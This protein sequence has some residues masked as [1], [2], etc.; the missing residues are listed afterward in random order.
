M[1]GKSGSY[2]SDFGHSLFLVYYW[3]QTKKNLL[4]QATFSVKYAHC[5]QNCHGYTN[6]FIII[7]FINCKWVDTQWQWSFYILHTHG[8]WRSITLDLVGEGYMGS[9]WWQLA[10][11]NNR[12][13]PS[14][15][16]RTQENQEKPV[17][18]WPVAGPSSYW[19]LSCCLASK[20]SRPALDMNYF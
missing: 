12:N 13:H 9:M 19:L 2:T 10:K 7:I 6:V 17:S 8:L 11:E 15:C 16:S 1:N 4:I 3:C 20:S 18:R 5:N 14:I